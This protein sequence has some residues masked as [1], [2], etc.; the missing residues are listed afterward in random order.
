MKNDLVAIP[1]ASSEHD[2]LV[3][4]ADLRHLLLKQ[5][6]DSHCLLELRFDDDTGAYQTMIMELVPE[7]GYLVLDALV[8]GEGDART[9]TQ[10]AVHVRTRL[11]GLDVRFSSRITQR[12]VEDGE[13]FYKVPYPVTVDYPQRRREHRV[14]VPIGKSVEVVFD[15]GGGRALTGEV[16]DLSPSGFSARITSGDVQR[17]Q[18]DAGDGAAPRSAC[19]LRL[20]DDETVQATVDVLHVFPGRGR[21]AP[22]LGVCFV[23]LEPRDERRIERYVAELDREQTRTR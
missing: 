1:L 21:A 14:T 6:A 12:G 5:V 4:S 20:P 3:D 10:P 8:P 15:G 18:S 13:P 2:E 11:N 17:L 7:H 22:R 19:E 23:A 16:R 9:A